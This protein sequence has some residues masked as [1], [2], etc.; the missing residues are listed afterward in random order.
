MLTRAF[1]RKIRE[2][3]AANQKKRV[4]FVRLQMKLLSSQLMSVKELLMMVL[5]VL[6]VLKCR[7]VWKSILR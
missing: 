6:L 1:R 7:R 4:E 3:R 2:D 5:L